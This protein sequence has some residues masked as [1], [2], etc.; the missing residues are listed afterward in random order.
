[1]DASLGKCR[2]S[3]DEDSQPEPVGAF[4]TA[5]SLYGM[6]DA[7]GNVWDWT[8]SF[9]DERCSLRV[10]RGGSWNNASAYLCCGIRLACAPRHRA[11]NVGFR[12]ARG[13]P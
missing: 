2:D 8:E 12:G 5:A 7:A 13:L 6:G 4:P 9:F 11:A 10:L 1:M 3:R